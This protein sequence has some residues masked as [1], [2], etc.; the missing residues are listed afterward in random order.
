[1]KK[2]ERSPASFAATGAPKGTATWNSFGTAKNYL[3]LTTPPSG[4]TDP[5]Q[6]ICDFWD[7]IGYDLRKV[8]ST[9]FTALA[10]GASKR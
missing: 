5:F 7:P 3:W 4:P 2:H 1:M 8:P 6:S 9:L 10:Q